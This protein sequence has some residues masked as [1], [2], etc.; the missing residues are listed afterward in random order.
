MN[1]H[2]VILIGS[3][4]ITA[5]AYFTF[6]VVLPYAEARI[7]R[8][9]VCKEQGGV[10]VEQPNSPDLCIKREHIIKS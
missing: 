5:Y 1:E 6:E 4:L 8:D 2:V 10:I 7:Y 9:K 3:V